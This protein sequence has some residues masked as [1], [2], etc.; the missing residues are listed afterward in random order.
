MTFLRFVARQHL[1]E[2]CYL[3]KSF[4]KDRDIGPFWSHHLQASIHTKHSPLIVSLALFCF[5]PLCSHINYSFRQLLGPGSET[6]AG[7]GQ[8]SRALY[9]FMT[10]HKKHCT[11]TRWFCLHIL[12]KMPNSS[13]LLC[14]LCCGRWGWYHP[15]E[16]MEPNRELWSALSHTSR[17]GCQDWTTGSTTQDCKIGVLRTFIL[18]LC[19]SK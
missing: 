6:F 1:L 4:Q 17:E 3:L 7:S 12:L 5:K 11:A 18:I 13:S 8:S 16:A 2:G 14:W 9:D 15:T 19:N 10:D